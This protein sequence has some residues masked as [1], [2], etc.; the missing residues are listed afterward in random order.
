[1][2]RIAFI[3]L[4]ILAF[5]VTA[6]TQTPPL[7]SANAKYVGYAGTGGGTANAQTITY[8]PALTAYTDGQVVSWLP[9]NPNSGAATLNING[10]GA[11]S[12]VKTQGAALALNDLTTT[13]KAFAIYD[14]TGT[15][16]ELLNPQ[17]GSVASSIACGGL[18]ALTGDTTTSAGS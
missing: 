6:Q 9:S 4:A 12:I 3:L 15:V 18:P 13:A 17:T 7:F 8:S 16:F 1:M 5:A 11:K 14:S 2:R 10:L